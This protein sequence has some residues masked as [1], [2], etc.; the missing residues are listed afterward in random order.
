MLAPVFPDQLQGFLVSDAGYR[1][2][3]DQID[4]RIL[5]HGNDG[6]AGFLKQFQHSLRII[7]IHLAAKRMR[8]DS[9]HSISP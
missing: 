5:I 8:C 6:I 9:F 4:V 7:L 3:V 2:G 1:A